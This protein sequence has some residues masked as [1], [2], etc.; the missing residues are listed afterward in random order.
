VGSWY[1]R[2]SFNTFSSYNNTIFCFS[3]F[4]QGPMGPI[5]IPGFSPPAVKGEKY[6]AKS[7]GKKMKN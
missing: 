7:K 2:K 5:G 3:F 1:E 6:F 4:P